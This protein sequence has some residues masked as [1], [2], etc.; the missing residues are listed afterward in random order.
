MAMRCARP[1]TRLPPVPPS[2]AKAGDVKGSSLLSR[3]TA[4]YTASERHQL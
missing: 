1:Q 4:P 3:T 2:R